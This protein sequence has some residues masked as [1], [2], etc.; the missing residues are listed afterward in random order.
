MPL[1]VLAITHVKLRSLSIFAV[2]NNF[3][4]ASVEIKVLCQGQFESLLEGID[5]KGEVIVGEVEVSG[6]GT[7]THDTM[8]GDVQGNVVVDLIIKTTCGSTAG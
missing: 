1:V 6:D 7:T 2:H 3:E 8:R 4:V 5:L